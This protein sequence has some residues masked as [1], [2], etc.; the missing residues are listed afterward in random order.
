[1][2]LSTFFSVFLATLSVGVSASPV[3]TNEL[4]E[5]KPEAAETVDLSLAKRGKDDTVEF[6]DLQEAAGSHTLEVGKWYSFR[7]EWTKGPSP[8]YNAKNE[9]MAEVQK[10]YGFDHTAIALV[11]VKKKG[12]GKNVNGQY[13]HLVINEHGD[14][15]AD[16]KNF[17]RKYYYVKAKP[18]IK[19]DGEAIL[20][21]KNNKEKKFRDEGKQLFTS[22]RDR[23][24]TNVLI[25][26]ASDYPKGKKWEAK[27]TDC[28]TY[29]DKLESILFSK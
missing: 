2:K 21:K 28:K 19:F 6:N 11:Q 10:D 1:M 9:D 5:T 23:L 13:Y 3:A 22:P 14:A 29:V 8:G 15:E 24:T 20:T 18:E 12:K 16:K 17:E 4:R 25:T 7:L 26:T 27:K